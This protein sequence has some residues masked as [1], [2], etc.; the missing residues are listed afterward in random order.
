MTGL[1][2]THKSLRKIAK[3]LQQQGYSVERD[4]LARLLKKQKFSLR[5][6]RKRLAKTH[7]PQRDQQFRYLASLR[8]RCL[9]KGEP[10]ISVDTKKKE[11]VGLFRREGTSWRQQPL[12]AWDHDFPS[13]ATG[14]AIPFGIYDIAHND[15]LVVVGLSHETAE[16]AACSIS[17]WWTRVGCWRYA[18][19]PRLLI[20]CDNGGPNGSR[21]WSWKW[22]LQKLA[23]KTRL[24]ITV[25]HYPPGASKWNW[26]EHKMFSLISA[27]WSGEI[28]DSFETILNFISTT[29]SATGFSCTALLDE[30]E[31]DTKQKPTKEERAMINLEPRSS[32][33]QWNYT[34]RPNPLHFYG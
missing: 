30:A 32:I 27:N 10:V 14:K 22:E 4:T 6:N 13:W 24:A 20:Q 17:K 18:G 11:L 2:W 25:Q 29:T 31:Y 16:F 9:R 34:I 28:L 5:T 8:T 26:I 21:A 19:T 12:N 3:E 15:G 23:N 1:K 33:P 7:H